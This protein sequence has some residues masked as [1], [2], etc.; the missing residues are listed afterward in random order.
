MGQS[1]DKQ[2]ALLYG[3]F[4]LAAY[5][6]FKNQNPDPLRPEP[7]GIPDGW[8]VGAWI[9]M[10]DFV[11]NLEEP[12]FYGI[13]AHEIA[14]EDSRIIAI[15][16]TEGPVEW[17]D[18]GDALL[19]PFHQV[20]ATGRVSQGFDR[21]YGTLK[22]VRRPLP[23]PG[24]AP[25]GAAAASETFAGSF[26]EQ[27]DQLAVIR[28]KERGFAASAEG[29]RRKRPTIVTGHSLGAALTT[30]FVMENAD[31]RKFDITTSCTFASPRVGNMDFARPFNKLPIVSWRIF[32]KHDLVTKIPPHIPIVLDYEHVNDAYEINSSGYAKNNLLCWHEMQ[33]YLHGLDQTF[34]VCAECV[35]H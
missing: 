30:L 7:A 12:K 13:V 8:E 19:V 28:E 25:G 6:M 27:L 24:V 4:V 10:S 15:R 3:K 22:V 5:T 18:D 17:L 16:G 31:K 35:L 32:N 34:P 9:H 14:N 1:L 23:R 2:K 26:A 20:P 29:A 33:T 11:L 21:I